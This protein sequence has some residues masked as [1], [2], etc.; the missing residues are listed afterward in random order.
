M[1]SV[2]C[3][4][5]PVYTLTDTGFE[6]GILDVMGRSKIFTASEGVVNLGAQTLGSTIDHL[7]YFDADFAVRSRRS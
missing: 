3:S 1:H 2:H 6:S 5:C 4:V 7:G